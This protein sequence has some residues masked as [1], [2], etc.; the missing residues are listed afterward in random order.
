LVLHAPTQLRT[1][2]PSSSI[3]FLIIQ[4]ST[5]KVLLCIPR[6][7]CLYTVQHTQLSSW[8]RV[9]YNSG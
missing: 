9:L 3:S 8:T 7:P 6:P 1:A 5:P 4:A 2:M